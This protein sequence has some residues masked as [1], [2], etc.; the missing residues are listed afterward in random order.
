MSVVFSKSDRLLGAA[1][2]QRGQIDE[3]IRQYQ[4]TL[5]LNPDA[6]EA[7]YN[8]GVTLAAK[9]QT[10]EAIRQFQ[11]ALRLKPDFAQARDDLARALRTNTAPAGR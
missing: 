9:G 7:H 8:L 1:L 3:A 2:G 11:E 10:D 4:E 5:R 6:A